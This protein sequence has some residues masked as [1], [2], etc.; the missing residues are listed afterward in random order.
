VLKLAGVTHPP[1]RNEQQVR[2]GTSQSAF[3]LATEVKQG[4]RFET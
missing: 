3:F 2:F 1:A 4:A